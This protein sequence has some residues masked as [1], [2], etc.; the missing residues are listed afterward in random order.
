MLKRGSS[1]LFCV[2]SLELHLTFI[3]MGTNIEDIQIDL[4]TASEQELIYEIKR[5]A[6][7]EEFFSSREQGIKTF[8]NSVYGATGNLGFAM[9][10]L[11]V[12]EAIT[13]QSRQM[14][15][16]ASWVLD[17]YFN[18]VFPSDK[19]TWDKLELTEEQRDTAT[20]IPQILKFKGISTLE[21]YSDTDSVYAQLGPIV[22]AL[23]VPE[24][25]HI[26]MAQK[27][28]SVAIDPYLI[29]MFDEYANTLNAP[30][31]VQQL[32]LEKIAYS[33]TMFA[34][35][36]YIM[37]LAWKEPDIYLD[38]YTSIL[39]RGLDV[40]KSSTP[41]YAREV[42]KD[43][44]IWCLKKYID[45]TLNVSNIIDKLREVKQEFE[46]QEPDDIC[47]MNKVN[48]M[49]EKV[50]Y[51]TKERSLSFKRH[52]TQAI[53]GAAYHNMLIKNDPESSVK[54]EMIKSGDRVKFFETVDPIIPFFGYK[55]GKFPY[56]LPGLPKIDY[57]ALFDKSILSP[58]N[59]LFVVL[60]FKPLSIE[61]FAA[62]KSSGITPLF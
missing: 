8:L 45:G 33:V 7:A 54:Y 58:M 46:K 23:N 38:P 49:E 28:Y 27:I 3:Y 21:V 29:K 39:Y 26:E 31:N 16:Y 4:N 14:T 53:K 61:F 12:S 52:A 6:K 30:K 41:K 24:D 35:K 17:K 2:K 56:G 43:L 62:S 32:E 25:K 44:N 55:Q 50:I 36:N 20:K 15:R 19:E 60:G 51:N 11:R 42:M 18:D 10:D 34:K 9:H 47:P 40:V 59:R 22:E 13:L 5:L 48:G 37:N 1:S 57:N